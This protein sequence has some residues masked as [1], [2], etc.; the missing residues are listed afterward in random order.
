M[1]DMGERPPGASIDRI[2]NTKGYEPSNC[3]W[4][5]PITQQNNKTS[6]H[7]WEFR[8]ETKTIAEWA[9]DIGMPDYVLRL[10]FRRGW[11]P[12]RALTTPYLR[13]P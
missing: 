10:R 6:N 3:R 13:R 12:E 2:D 8:G 11:N 1:A 7:R 9:R 4:A 5:S